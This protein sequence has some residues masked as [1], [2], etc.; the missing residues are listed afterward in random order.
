MFKTAEPVLV[1]TT[2]DCASVLFT[3]LSPK[4]NAVVLSEALVI[5]GAIVKEVVASCVSV[6][7]VP[8]RVRVPV[9]GAALPDADM[10]I[11]PWEPAIID[12]LD[13]VAVTPAG[14]AHQKIEKRST[15]NF[16]RT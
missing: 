7:E 10:P 12:T 4:S 8:L 2:T 13:G 15:G 9:P 1:T 11:C 14:R 6:P 3:R 5:G 16:L